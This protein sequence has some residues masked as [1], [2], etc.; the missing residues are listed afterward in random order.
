MW[1]IVKTPPTI[2]Q[3]KTI[4]CKNGSLSFVYLTVIGLK[5]YLKTF[6]FSD[7]SKRKFN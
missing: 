2:A 1:A 5:S 7:K 4:K 6:E 3:I